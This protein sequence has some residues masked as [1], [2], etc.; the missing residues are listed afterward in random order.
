[1][2]RPVPG[3]GL[4]VKLRRLR[5]R[6]GISAPRV[7][8]RTHLPWYWRAL[9]V[10][11][12]AAISLALAGW[13]Y[14]AGRRFAGFEQNV[15]AQEIAS[16]RGRVAQMEAE[17]GAAL[18][19]ANGTESRLRIESTTQ[20]MLSSQIRALEEENTRL[21]ADLAMFENLAGG[22]AGESGLA[23]SRLQVTP[24]GELGDYRYRLLLA[25][26]GDKKDKEFKGLLQLSATVQRAGQ[27]VMMQFPAAGDASTAQYQ[28]NFRYFRRLE[29][30]FNVGRDAQVR[31][32]EARLLQD[33]AVKASQSVTLP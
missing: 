14:D 1:V 8:V 4:T 26:T 18:K 9:S 33:G 7:A 31:R 24:L 5:G 23:I 21:K 10:I 22:V 16:M 13:I 27:A 15:S 20:E 12:L 6:F 19:V 28:V 3:S 32:V 17:L 25:Q 2:R 29:G 30:T 11:V